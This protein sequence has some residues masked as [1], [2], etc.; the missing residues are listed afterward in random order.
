MNKVNLVIVSHPDDEILG[1]GGT[2]ALLFEAGEKIQPIILCGK[3]EERSKRPKDNKLKTHIEKANSKVGF[4]FPILG[5]FLN[6]KLNT[7]NHIDLVKFIEKYIFEFNPYR[8]FTHHPTDLNNDHTQVSLA[9]QAA[10][11]YFQRKNLN[12]NLK[13]ILLMEI[14][15]STDWAFPVSQPKFNPNFYID[16]TNYIDKKISA[17][18]EYENVMREAPHPRSEHAIKGHAAFRGGQCGALYAESFELIYNKGL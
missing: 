1:L 3:V 7:V 6:I 15:S 11:R 17:L 4:N 13:S 8:I 12:S 2:G 14:L 16:I 18:S 10:S 9:C 5:D